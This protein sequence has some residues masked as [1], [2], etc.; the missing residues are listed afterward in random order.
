MASDTECLG[1]GQKF[2]QKD[3][4][5]Q[6]TICGLW[7]H[8]TCSGVTNELFKCLSDQFKATGRAYWACR[9]CC[10]YAEGMT[11]RLRQLE[12]K[13]AEATRMG[14][15]N[16]KEIRSLREEVNTRDKQLERRIE[17]GEDSI[18]EEMN[19]RDRRKKNVVLYGVQESARGDGRQRMEDDKTEL[20]EIFT[21]M[22][23]NLAAKDDVEFCR[24]VGAK[25]DTPR[26]LICGFYSEWAKNTLLR[27]SKRLYGTTRSIYHPR[28]H[29]AAEKSGS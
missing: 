3:T 14:E 4:S 2:K 27:H 22:D 18:F 5:I 26:P 15:E 28:P 25:G 21:V 16:A 6:C 19:K 7:A 11:H 20:N 10:A 13:T 1:C 8:K 24:R 17:N 12:E 23:V 9:S 29:Q